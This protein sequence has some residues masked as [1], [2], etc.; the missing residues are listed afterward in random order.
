MTGSYF[1]LYSNK[2][3]LFAYDITEGDI[4]RP[5]NI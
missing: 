1:F 2:F 3:D 5:L 4:Y